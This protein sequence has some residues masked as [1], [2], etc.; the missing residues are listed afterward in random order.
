MLLVILQLN[1]FL[2]LHQCTCIMWCLSLVDNFTESL[3]PVQN[4]YTVKGITGKIICVTNLSKYHCCCS[5][6]ENVTI[7][8]KLAFYNCSMPR[9]LNCCRPQGTLK[10]Y[11]QKTSNSH[12]NVRFS[13][14]SDAISRI[15]S[16]CSLLNTL[17]DESLTK[18]WT[19]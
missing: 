2:P 3:L 8:G 1:C 7:K 14:Y 13:V 19:W 6:N 18:I 5:C 10:L 4:I 12:N 15:L 11:I 9:K 16:I 17:R